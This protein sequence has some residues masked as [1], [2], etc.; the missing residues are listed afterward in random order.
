[1][2]SVVID[3]KA[4]PMRSSFSLRWLAVTVFVISS[5]LNYLDRALLATLAPL[6]MAELHFNQTGFGF[7]ISAFS[8][9]Y[10]AS[11]LITGWFLDR[12]G[13][14]KGISA[15]VTWWSAA[16][17]CTGMVRSLPGLAI[18]RAALGVG[19]SAGVPAVG[20]LNGIYLKPEERALGA[21]VNQIG[22]SVGL[23]IAPLC[24]G[25]AV[26]NGW[27]A[28]FLL[29]GLLGFAWIP[30]WWV[31]SRAIP[32]KFG[33]QEFAGRGTGQRSS[34]WA[35]LLD[36]NLILLV[37]A[38]VLWMGSYSLWSN[39]TTLYLMRV[40]GLTLR[41]TAGYTWIPPLISNAGGFFGGWLS[42]H[43]M[44][45]GTDAVSARR[46]AIL[47][48][49]AG[50]L[51]TLLVPFAPD[52][53]WATALISASFFFALAGSVNIYALPI[54]IF[55]PARAGLAIA[56][57]TCAFGLLQTVISPVIGFLSEHRL[58]TQIVW[59]VTLPLIAS[60]FV[61]GALRTNRE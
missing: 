56:A 47:V 20:K 28:P 38:N 45:R 26:H 46:R 7:L 40:H 34:S 53:R 30:L 35:M 2:A 42:L 15:A 25:L 1:V 19:E 11:S 17:L 4:L 37:I 14:T 18:C 33:D 16:A 5:T 39:W 32:P 21:A 60:A 59:I 6:L 8:I 27:R 43:W 3:H 41:Q 24:I 29:T 31:L 48:S 57:L 10:A 9:A 22:L 23:A 12:V 61:L 36:R 52:A 44:K 50:S 54:D 55:G 13:V 49:A 51:L 58:Y